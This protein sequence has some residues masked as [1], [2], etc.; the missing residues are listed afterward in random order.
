MSFDYDLFVIGAGSGGV[1]ASRIAANL[2]AKV[3]VVED[4]FMGGTCVNVGCVP[5]KLFVYASEYSE[6]FKASG[7]FG[8]QL[9]GQAGFD[10]PT[11]RDNKTK[12][13]ERLNELYE[14]MLGGANVDVIH[15]HGKL[16]G[17]HQVEVGDKIYS[18]K[19]IIIATGGTPRW[20]E[21]DGAE[22][23]ITSD[24]VFYLDTL[25][26]R[27][28][29]QGGGYIAV[30][31]AGIF[32]GLK[33]KT[34][35]LYRGDYFLRGFDGEIREFVASQMQSKGVTLSFNTDIEKID[36][37]P[38]GSLTVTLTTGETREVDAVLS[39]IGR[40]PRIKGLGLENT[41]VVTSQT[42]FIEVDDHFKT[43]EEGV[44]ALGDVVG[45]MALTPVALAEGMALAKHLFDAQP[46]A[47]DYN[48]IAT[49]VFCQPNIATVGLTEEQ[50]REQLP[51]VS[52]FKSDFK[53]MKHTLSGLEERTLMKIVV[54]TQSDKVVGC[55]MVG[56]EAAEIMQGIAIAMVA[57]ATKADFDKTIGIHPSAAEEFVT[58]RSPSA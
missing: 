56:P 5:K 2:G 37:N 34:E 16:L 9:N 54:D 35:L 38:D 18:A 12:E 51:S 17:N 47:L 23:C 6:H 36:K 10:W 32:N 53:A 31:F 3:A 26:K 14:R 50:A 28:L 15:G 11:L 30:E 57:G 42:G 19:H 25:P 24:Q 45:R 20:P 58:M 4:T 21:F 44:Y 46:I 39:A 55:H 22:H 48:N 13:I 40:V 8:W 29:V 43:A 7:G 1:R 27:V 33:C 49:A 52:I 41:Q